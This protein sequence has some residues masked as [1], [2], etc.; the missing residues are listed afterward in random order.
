MDPYDNKITQEEFRDLLFLMFDGYIGRKKKTEYER[1]FWYM[2][3]KNRNRLKQKEIPY[4]F[5]L[6]VEI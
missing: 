6:P 3:G 1:L 5:L 2:F 4:C